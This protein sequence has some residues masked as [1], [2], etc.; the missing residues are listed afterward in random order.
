MA[1]ILD[2][3]MI[4]S[5]LEVVRSNKIR[6]VRIQALD[7]VSRLLLSEQGWREVARVSRRKIINLAPGSPERRAVLQL[8]VRNPLLSVRTRLR[9]MADDPAEL[10]AG[11]IAEALAK[12]R[13]PSQ[14]LRVLDQVRAGDYEK[15]VIL[16]GLPLEDSKLTQDDIPRLGDEAYSDARLWR[17]LALARLR[18]YEPLDAF[19]LG[20]VS[21]PEM[22]WGDPWTPYNLISTIRPIPPHMHNHLLSVMQSLEQREDFWSDSWQMRVA[23]A[24]TGIANAEGTP[25]QDDEGESDR[26]SEFPTMESGF[27]PDPDQESRAIDVSIALLN[28]ERDE[29]DLQDLAYL[30]PERVAPFVIEYIRY[31]N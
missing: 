29:G 4:K 10:D 16:A 23:Q 19:L 22:F 18:E 26:A 3:S 1:Q 2:A 27:E 24:A 7:A 17:A 28:P 5:L 9:E 30:P 13:D 12:M 25:L 11:V 15:L 6:E 31:M 8:S 20:D 14:T 21:E